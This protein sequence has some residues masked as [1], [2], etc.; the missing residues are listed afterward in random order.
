MRGYEKPL[1]KP[2]T[3]SKPFW[4][5]CKNRKLLIQQCEDCKKYI[6]Y[7]KL[8]CPFCLSRDLSWVE[9]TGRGTIYTFTVVYSYQP[10]GFA[11][12]VPYT[13]AV[14][15]LSEGIRIMSNIVQCPPEEVVCDMEVEVIFDDV[16]QEITLPKF[17][18]VR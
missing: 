7:P 9:S 16:T 2:S 4:D 10:T 11:D 1:P 5:G 3:W 14:V 12:D 17:K 15:K 8:F 13:I 18:P 6:F